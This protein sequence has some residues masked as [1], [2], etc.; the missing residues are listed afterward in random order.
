MNFSQKDPE[1]NII[2]WIL[3]FSPYHSAVF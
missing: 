1:E 2:L 3:H